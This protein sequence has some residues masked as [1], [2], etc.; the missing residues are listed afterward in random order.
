M[1]S[2]GPSGDQSGDGSWRVILGRFWGRFWV[3][4]EVISEKPHG[5]LIKQLHTAVGR[6][7]TAEYD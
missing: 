1:G 3:D 2:G 6:A 7:S 4:S 5:N